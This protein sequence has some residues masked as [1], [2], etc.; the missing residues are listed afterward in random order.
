LGVGFRGKGIRVEGLG[1]VYGLWC[2]VYG[3]WCM[4]YGLWFIVF[5]G[6]DADPP[7]NC[8]NELGVRV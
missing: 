4:V 2:V 6:G 7:T 8:S 3:L 5:H 1:Q